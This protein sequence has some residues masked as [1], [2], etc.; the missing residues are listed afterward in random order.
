MPGLGRADSVTLDPHKGLFLPYGTGCLV[1]RDRESLRRAHARHATYMPPMQTDPDLVD[2]CD[3]GPELSREARGLRVWL[4][5]KLHGAAAFREALDEKLD[6][7][8]HAA[9]AI[10][11]LPGVTL[12]AP[13]ELSLFAFRLATDESTR[14]LLA[15][16][17]ARQR[18][19]LTGAVVHDRFVIRVCILS[20]RTHRDRVDALIDDVR[21]GLAAAG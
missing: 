21:Q 2:F 5:L 6:L 8:R 14:A 4:P 15:F 13:P 3:L 1:V 9:T 18:V 20:F 11:T 19:L 16:V 17:N 10:G 7:A 12:V